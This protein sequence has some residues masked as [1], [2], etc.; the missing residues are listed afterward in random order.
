LVLFLGHGVRR[1]I[2][3]LSRYNVPAPVVGGL[4]IAMVMLAARSR[5]VQLVEDQLHE[6]AAVAARR[7]QGKR[8]SSLLIT[9]CLNIWT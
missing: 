9:I 7:R 2:P 5:G 8:W 4:L 1:F 3:A 6:P